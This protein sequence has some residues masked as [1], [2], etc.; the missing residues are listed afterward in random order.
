MTDAGLMVNVTL[1]PSTTDD[2]SG[3]P[4]IG[5]GKL[6]TCTCRLVVGL[7]ATSPSTI[8]PLDV[9]LYQQDVVTL[10]V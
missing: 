3:V 1:V 10:I 4:T 7:S 6:P 5:E 2:T 9:F 8:C